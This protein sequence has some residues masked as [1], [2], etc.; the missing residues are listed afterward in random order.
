SAIGFLFSAVP[1][2]VQNLLAKSAGTDFTSANAV[3]FAAGTSGA[4]VDGCAP[5]G[6]EFD[7][8]GVLTPAQITGNT[9][10]Y[11]PTGLANASVLRLQTD[12]SRNLTGLTG[13]SDRREILI[14][15]I[16]GFDLVLTDNDAAS[17]AGNRFSMGGNTT[18]QTNEGIA[19][20]YD[21]AST[22]WR[23]YGR[24]V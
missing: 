6:P 1:A 18:L 22:V 5:G 21:A 14:F 19:F 8:G 15:N 13:G 24:T 3:S 16:G 2:V 7:G 4:F 11:A 17:T 23:S 9:N 12:A 10:N 20:W